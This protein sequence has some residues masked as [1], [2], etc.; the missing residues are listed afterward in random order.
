[1]TR[2][3]QS[4]KKRLKR[5]FRPITSKIQVINGIDIINRLGVTDEELKPFL[6]GMT[7]S[8][9]I[10]KKRLFIIDLETLEGITCVEGHVVSRN[11]LTKLRQHEFKVY[12]F[13]NP[14]CRR[15]KYYYRV[16]HALKNNC[17]SCCFFFHFNTCNINIK[18]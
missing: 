15:Q 6:E 10:S 9:A 13:R 16:W 12:C 18:S 14:V 17:Q 3:N 2:K 5:Y 11:N 1:M 8:E 4:S 7:I